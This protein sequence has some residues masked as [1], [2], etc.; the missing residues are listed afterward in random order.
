MLTHFIQALAL[1]LPSA[2]KSGLGIG[3]SPRSKSVYLHMLFQ[4]LNLSKTL[5]K[6]LSDLGFTSPTPIQAK[7]FPVILS[8]R[9]AVGIAQTGTGKTFAYL[10]PVLKQLSYSEMRQPRVL[11]LLPTRE[12]V[13]QVVNEVKKLTTYQSVRVAGIYGGANI[14]TQ[15][16]LIYNGLDVLVSTPGRI[17]DMVLTRTLQLQQIQKVVMDEVDELMNLGFRPQLM[18]VLD[19]LPPKKQ[20]L[21]FSATLNEEAEALINQY[22]REPI[23]L[24]LN[25]RGSAIEEIKQLAYAIPN[26]YSKINTLE[27]LLQNNPDFKRVLVFIKNKKLADTIFKELDPL[28]PNQLS[29]IHSNKTQPQRSLSLQQFEEGTR[30]VL[31]ATDIVARGLDFEEVSHVIN[32][33]TPVHPDEYIHRIGRTGRAGKSGTAITFFT[34]AEQKNKTLIE[35]FIKKTIS[36]LDLP[37]DVELTEALIAEEEPVKRDKNLAK[38]KKLE[39]PTGAFHEKKAKNKKIQ[40][41]GKRRQEKL[42]RKHTLISKLRKR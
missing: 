17:M 18:Q 36:V 11:I 14:N 38:Q 4:E 37:A 24:E 39:V 42:K 29:V 35:T 31:I 16:Q 21:L 32:F 5:L 33:D 2:N 25:Q 1:T 19:V 23:Y 13:Q 28:L 26:F 20:C 22:F 41:G 8:G 30:R 15:K 7:S 9:D 10:L 3:I 34:A 12:L 27:Y 6:A 40:L